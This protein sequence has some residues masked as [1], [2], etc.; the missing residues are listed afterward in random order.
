MQQNTHVEPAL[1]GEKQA[2]TGQELLTL[3]R[4]RGTV[5]GLA[6]PPDGAA[7]ACRRRFGAPGRDRAVAADLGPAGRAR[8]SPP[9]RGPTAAVSPPSRLHPTL[10]TPRFRPPALFALYVSWYAFGR[11]FE[12]LLRVDPSHHVFGQRLN[13]WVSLV[14]FLGSTGFF[15][16]WQRPGRPRLPQLPR[17]PRRAKPEPKAA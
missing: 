3:R 4:P 14:L 9:Q 2:A 1:P 17:R 15:L 11:C 12:E 16:W 6:F 5:T 8:R 10:P 13:F 7:L